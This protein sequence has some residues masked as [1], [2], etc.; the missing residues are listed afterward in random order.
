MNVFSD[1]KLCESHGT[2]EA[3]AESDLAIETSTSTT[4]TTAAAT[5]ASATT[6]PSGG[7]NMMW[8]RSRNTSKAA[9]AS[10]PT[11]TA[12]LKQQPTVP[13]G[14]LWALNKPDLGW[15]ALG[16]LGAA[17]AGVVPALDAYV[18]VHFLVRD[19]THTC[20]LDAHTITA[21]LA[22]CYLRQSRL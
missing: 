5:A 3:A 14:Q 19:S 4:F 15:L 1:T 22:P 2:E 9:V 18:V 16:L 10:A 21:T 7:F 11:A 20:L 6:T 17:M 12:P 8:S 13:I